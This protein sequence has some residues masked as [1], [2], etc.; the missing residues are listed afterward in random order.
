MLTIPKVT[1]YPTNNIK[2]TM[3]NSLLHTRSLMKTA[4]YTVHKPVPWWVI[5]VKWSKNIQASF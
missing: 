3:I 1:H 4:D 2:I 5:H